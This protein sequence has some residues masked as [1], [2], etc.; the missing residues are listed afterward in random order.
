MENL[1]ELLEQAIDANNKEE[2]DR[3][4]AV[5]IKEKNAPLAY[6]FAV[7]CEDETKQLQ[8][9]VIK[10]ADA[11]LIYLFARDVFGADIEKLERAI[12]ETENVSAIKNFANLE[13][14]NRKKL[15]KI[16]KQIEEC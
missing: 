7:E 14:A 3:I 13:D 1:E 8:K 5:I 6:R 2:L 11:S 12:I 16:I 10:S 9:I 15:L 4:K